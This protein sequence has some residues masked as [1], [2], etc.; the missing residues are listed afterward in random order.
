[1]IL[2]RSY[3]RLILV[4]LDPTGASRHPNG[5]LNLRPLGEAQGE[6]VAVRGDGMVVLTSE[7][8][9]VSPTPGMHLLRCTFPPAP[10]AAG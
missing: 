5:Q 6:A 7:A 1:M 10:V 2:I 4:D 3:D 8:G 9:P